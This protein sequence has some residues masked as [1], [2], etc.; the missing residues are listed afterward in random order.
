MWSRTGGRNLPSAPGGDGVESAER[1]VFAHYREILADLNAE[2]EGGF[3]DRCSRVLQ[4]KIPRSLRQL[5]RVTLVDLVQL[6][7]AQR[8]AVHWFNERAATLLVT[9][10]YDASPNLQEIY[11]GPAQT[12]DF[13]LGLGFSETAFEPDLFRP[14]GLRRVE[15]EGLAPARG[16][17]RQESRPLRGVHLR[18]APRGEGE[19]L[20][21]ARETRRLLSEG[22]S[23]DQVLIMAPRWTDESQV[24]LDMLRAWG[25][26]AARGSS[27][28]LA[29]NPLIS[30]LGRLVNLPVENWE[31][32]S[33]VRLLRS[34]QLQPRWSDS[35]D[36]IS[37]ATAASA[38]HETRVFRGLDRIQ[39]ALSLAASNPERPILQARAVTA[40]RVME[41]LARDLASVDR[42]ASWSEHVE[43]LVALS[44]SLGLGLRESDKA[45]LE[46]LV[47]ALEEQG[48]VHDQLSSRPA[49]WSW[50]A[51]VQQV[52]TL[53][54]RLRIPGPDV[55]AGEVI[56]TTVDEAEAARARAVFLV[57]LEEGQF[58]SREAVEPPP[59]S[60]PT[61]FT[62]F[63]REVLRFLRAV[64]S[65]DQELY[66]VYP[67]VDRSGQPILKSG[68]LDDLVRR[69]RPSD[70]EILTRID[71]ALLDQGELAG[72]RA[73]RLV[74]AIAL[75]CVRGQ[76]EE[77][78]EL[79]RR[80]DDQPILHGVAEAFR[81]AHVRN[82]VR[83]YGRFE[84]Q[85]EHTEIVRRVQERF[86]AEHIFSPSQ[87]EA[88]V[89]CPFQ[90]FMKSVLRLAPVDE[91]GELESDRAARGS[92]IHQALELMERRNLARESGA[93]SELELDPS[94][95]DALVIEEL[96]RSES[97]F[98]AGMREV[99]IG[100]LRKTVRRYEAQRNL[101]R[102]PKQAPAIPHRFEIVFGRERD[103]RSL[104][105]LELDA[106]GERIRLQGQIDR[107][108]LVSIE[109]DSAYR[110]IDYKTGSS[111]SKT[112]IRSKVALQLPL[113]AVAV[114][115]LLF[116][117]DNVRL[118][119]MGYWSL[120]PRS[121][122]YDDA[123]IKQW[124]SFAR[125][126]LT[127]LAERIRDL[128]N[129][130]FPV[131]PSREDCTRMC[132]FRNACRIRQVRHAGKNRR[133]NGL[134]EGST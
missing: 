38:I 76:Q 57:Q 105:V 56:V 121:K 132:D 103:P 109:G 42:A 84:G 119:D 35:N 41:H 6:D 5:G 122:G 128:R 55:G 81:L 89:F 90:F 46:S 50:P 72:G 70:H 51:F 44:S 127:Y 40:G 71:P 31:T 120:G 69:L 110:I 54:R 88:F 24:L 113:Y 107:L 91:R 96:R 47:V 126:V 62:P 59:A 36:P 1:S 104:P 32:S 33:L 86:G 64:G 92:V 131:D 124:E 75:A 63:G 2:D 25:I 129:A 82:R 93:G 43:D 21:V 65:A 106:D 99:E 102:G 100:I 117:G 66:L 97:D 48:F 29:T 133:A 26:P 94:I 87:L 4:E 39:T 125:E 58:P 101:Y 98:E 11:A 111:P 60:G 45:L 80:P 17:S 67:T 79:A 20:V 15:S 14:E 74:R 30:V 7:P 118:A 108:D 73:D 114:E 10:T 61:H 13:L 77:L 9:L 85:L 3:A 28:S 68:F 95:L 115:R 16:A 78:A 34:G 123:G 83:E 27:I 112:D 116:P 8:R 52:E 19:A 23:P 18:G 12:R 53:V 130:R 37:L 49:H 22:L 134:S